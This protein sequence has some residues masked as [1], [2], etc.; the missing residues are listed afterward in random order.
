MHTTLLLLTLTLQAATTH[1]HPSGDQVKERGAHV[2]GFDQGKTTHHFRLHA[3]GGSIDIAVKD[4]SDAANRDAIRA[5]LP[6]I[7][8]MFG[9]GNFSA[10]MLIHDTNVPGTAQMTALKNRMRFAYV[11]TSRGGR[12]DIYTTDPDAIAAVHEFMRFQ[13]ADHKTGDPVTVTKR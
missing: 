9:D 12:L 8:Q 13:I 5:H 1:Q 3:D 4:G 2:M 10:P 11:E 6:H 7:T